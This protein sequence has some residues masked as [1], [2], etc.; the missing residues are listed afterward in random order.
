MGG[1]VILA[2]AVINLSLFFGLA[3][4]SQTEVILSV[5][6]VNNSCFILDPTLE[7]FQENTFSVT[8]CHI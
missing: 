4:H 2:I 7:K 6:I 5:G 8:F 1:L 3:E